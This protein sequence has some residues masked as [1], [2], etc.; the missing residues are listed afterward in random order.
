MIS[1]A[2]RSSSG[3]APLEPA[4]ANHRF[5]SSLTF[6]GCSAAR[7]WTSARSTSVW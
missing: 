3:K 5:T 2:D 6:S 4:S 7:S 1:S